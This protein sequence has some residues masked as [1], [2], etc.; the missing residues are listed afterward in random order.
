[1]VQMPV[2]RLSKALKEPGDEPEYYTVKGKRKYDY[3]VWV[4]VTA[5]GREVTEY[6]TPWAATNHAHLLER[7]LPLNLD[8]EDRG[9]WEWRFRAIDIV[10][11]E[12]PIPP[13][14][15]DVWGHALMNMDDKEAMSFEEAVVMLRR[16]SDDANAIIE[17]KGLPKPDKSKKKKTKAEKLLGPM[18]DFMKGK[19]MVFKSPS[20]KKD[21]ML[22]LGALFLMGGLLVQALNPDSC[23]HYLVRG[24]MPP[25]LK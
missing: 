1:M 6:Y 12:K 25:A 2:P 24:E 19:G 20:P 4:V 15:A 18:S 13:E 16:A 5:D 9:D 11:Y 14:F 17:A 23:L 7:A 3:T 10:I 21:T 8:A 22:F